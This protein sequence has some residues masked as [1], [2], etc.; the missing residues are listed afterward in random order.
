MKYDVIDARISPAGG[1][2]VLSKAEVNTLLDTSQGGLYKLFRNCSLAVLNS[3]NES[4][5][6]EAL[7]AQYEDFDIEVIEGHHH[8]K[9]DA[10]SGTALMLGEAAAEG[11]GVKLVDVADRARDGIT[12]ARKRGDIGFHAIRGGDIVGE[13]DVLFAA[14]GE[15]IVLRHLATDRAIF[16]RGALKAALWGQGK[17]PGQ[18]DMVDVLGL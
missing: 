5:D 9:V 7:L 18:Y 1:M 16:A 15:R 4:D 11:R 10:P 2:E 12:G 17:A 6:A 13:H 14:P 3:G 8:H